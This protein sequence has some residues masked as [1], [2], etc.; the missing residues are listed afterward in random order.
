MQIL[1]FDGLKTNE[2]LSI[3]VYPVIDTFIIMQ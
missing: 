1:H 2:K 3:F